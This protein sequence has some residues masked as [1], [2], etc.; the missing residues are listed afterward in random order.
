MKK[1]IYFLLVWLLF[2]LSVFGKEYEVKELSMKIEIPDSYI[3]ITVDNYI[4]NPILE[5]LKITEKEISDTFRNEG[6]Y[7]TAY[8]MVSGLQFIIYKNDTSGDFRKN[9]S[10]QLREYSDSYANS[11]KK[12]GW[13]VIN[14]S[15]D[16]VNGIPFVVLEYEVEG[17]GIVDYVTVIEDKTYTFK[18]QME[19]RSLTEEH[20]QAL[21]TMLESLSLKMQPVSKYDYLIKVG[22]F[23]VVGGILALIK[24]KNERNKCPYCKFKISQDNSFCPRCGNRLKKNI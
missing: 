19:G 21:I 16:K 13:K 7:L 12:E 3:V 14:N 2:P 6:S 23:L 9:N 20:K 17:H 5:E 10:I 4:G 24:K 18:I 1:I 15:V 8:D 22:V 11:A